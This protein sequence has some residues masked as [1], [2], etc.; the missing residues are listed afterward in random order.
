MSFF[1][2]FA[3]LSPFFSCSCLISLRFSFF[4]SLGSGWFSAKLPR[5]PVT[6]KTQQ[7]LKHALA[8]L[9]AELLMAYL[10]ILTFIMLL[11]AS[12]SSLLYKSLINRMYII[13]LLL[14]CFL[15]VCHPPRPEPM[16]LL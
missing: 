12:P 1:I 5:H 3:S 7:A 14:L 15:P 6:T 8:N 10:S 16:D 4:C 2:F 11:I 13:Y 9:H